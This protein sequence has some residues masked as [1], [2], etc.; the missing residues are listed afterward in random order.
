MFQ[1]FWSHSIA[2]CDQKPQTN[3]KSLLTWVLWIE[4]IERKI[5][6]PIRVKS[7]YFGPHFMGYFFFFFYSL[8]AQ[9]LIHFYCIENMGQDLF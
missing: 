6:P 7:L 1:V 8:R 5:H 9:V 3:C 4:S 2:L